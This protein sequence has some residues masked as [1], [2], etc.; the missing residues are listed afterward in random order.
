MDYENIHDED[1]LTAVL[2][3]IRDLRLV[4]IYYFINNIL[5]YR[6]CIV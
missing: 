3:G 4:S 1:N 5:I 6:N 2:Y